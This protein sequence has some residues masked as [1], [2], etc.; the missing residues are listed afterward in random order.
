MLMELAEDSLTPFPASSSSCSTAAKMFLTP[1]WASSKLPRTAQTQTLSPS[2]VA[3]WACCT[4]LTP[5]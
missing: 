2:W 3:I 5:P 4:G 1:V